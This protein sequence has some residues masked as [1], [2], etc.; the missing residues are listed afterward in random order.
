MRSSRN[1]STTQAPRAAATPRGS[2]RWRRRSREEPQSCGEPA[3]GLTL[4]C[5]AQILAQFRHLRHREPLV[6]AYYANA[7]VFVQPSVSARLVPYATAGV[8]TFTGSTVA[9]ADVGNWRVV[10]YDR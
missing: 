1:S 6:N 9:N 10:Q 4:R 2:R 8:G 7:N 5:Q 3:R